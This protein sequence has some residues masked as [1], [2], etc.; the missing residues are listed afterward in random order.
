VNRLYRSIMDNIEPDSA[1]L[2]GSERDG[3]GVAFLGLA[4]E[5]AA[6][7]REDH[8]H[9]G[10]IPLGQKPARLQCRPL[11]G[12]GI[13]GDLGDMRQRPPFPEGALSS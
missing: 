12:A 11:T 10:P 8:P 2:I 6:Q 3:I 9:S 13:L 1:A 7:M 4:L 5:A